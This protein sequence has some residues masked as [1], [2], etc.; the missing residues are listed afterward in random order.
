MKNYIS[1]TD[2]EKLHEK[3]TLFKYLQSAPKDND[4]LVDANS[5]NRAESI[6]KKQGF[7]KLQEKRSNTIVNYGTIYVT[8]HGNEIYILDLM[9]R[10]DTTMHTLLGSY[11]HY[12]YFAKP[13]ERIICL[14]GPDGC[15][16]T[17]LRRILQ[18]VPRVKYFYYGDWEY[19]LQP[20][21]S[22]ILKRAKQPFKRVV[23]IGYVIENVLRLVAIFLY[24]LLGFYVVLERQPGSK[25]PRVGSKKWVQIL[26]GIYFKFFQIGQP[27]LIEVPAG[28]IMKRKQELSSQDILNHY[29]ALEYLTG[30]RCIKI[31]NISKTLDD[32]INTIL[33]YLSID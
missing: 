20:L 22:F 17:T 7:F 11:M 19:V 26:H 15:G 14:L 29:K 18:K 13:W 4:F 32:A 24:A 9:I 6:I 27:F 23:F 1:I 31:S 16:K 21:Y 25:I 3:G 5:F 12:F 10:K 30:S 33:K 2:L 28:A 8:C